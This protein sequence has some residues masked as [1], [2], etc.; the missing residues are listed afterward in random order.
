M[1]ESGVEHPDS[2]ALYFLSCRDL[3]DEE[4]FLNYRLT[5]HVTRPDWYT[6]V[7]EEEERRRWA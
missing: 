5:P 4:I 2:S 3:G 6:P 7:D 1:P